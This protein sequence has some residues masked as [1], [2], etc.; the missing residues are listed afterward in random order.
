MLKHKTLAALILAAA[1]PTLSFAMPNAEECKMGKNKEMAEHHERGEYRKER[2]ERDGHG[3]REHG[4]GGDHMRFLDLSKEQQE[5]MRAL[6]GEDMKAHH[7]ITKRYLDKLPEADR[8]AMQKDMEDSREK[9]QKAM[10]D[11]L[12]PEQQ[13]KF[14]EMHKKME[15]KR[16]EREEF[17]KWKAEQA[18]KAE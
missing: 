4:K 13:V 11:L 9:N 8:K 6:K 15:E 5:K 7:E 2:G 17:M 3:P 10:R 16:K 14:D 18:K 12:T 1:L